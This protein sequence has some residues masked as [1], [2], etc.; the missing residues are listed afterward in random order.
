M[1][2]EKYVVELQV[3]SL[4]SALTYTMYI[5]DINSALEPLFCMTRTSA[6]PYTKDEAERVAHTLSYLYG[7]RPTAELHDSP[8]PPE[9][10][11]EDWWKGA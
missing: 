8:D 11:S 6:M 7:L 5:A 4:Q 9:E 3:G 2:S 1:S 10:D